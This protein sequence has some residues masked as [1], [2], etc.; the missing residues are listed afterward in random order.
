VAIA[1]KPREVREF[2]GRKFI[3]EEA[4]TGD[5]S[6]IKGWKADTRGNIVFRC[7]PHPPHAC[8]HTLTVVHIILYIY[9]LF[10]Y[11]IY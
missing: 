6:L 11:C 8:A 10:I 4:I 7:T 5:F 3:M 9:I 1:S 2:N